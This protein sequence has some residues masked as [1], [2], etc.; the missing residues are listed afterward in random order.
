MNLHDLI[1]TIMQNY[2]D[3]QTER[4]DDPYKGNT[5]AELLRDGL[6]NVSCTKSLLSNYVV[7]GSAGQGRWSILPWIG[8]FDKD[9]SDSPQKSYYLAYLFS[10]EMDNAYLSLNQGWTFFKDHYTQPLETAEQVNDYWRHHLTINNSRITTADINLV[11]EKRDRDARLGNEICNIASIHYVKNNLPDNQQM[12]TDL[13]IMINLFQELK[14]KLHSTN[15]ET[16]INDI[17]NNQ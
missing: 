7:K 9:L 11:K 13:Q 2:P 8:I 10:D 4:L 3:D 6:Q 15:L 1:A 16:S 14:Q 5:T 17:I 12:I